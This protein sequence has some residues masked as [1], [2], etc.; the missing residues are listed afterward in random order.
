M[1]T[2][3]YQVLR[4]L[5]DRVSGEFVNLGIVVYE[6]KKKQLV[7]RFYQKIT[8]VSSFFPTVNS[9]YLAST[10]K[11][12][13]KEFES[14]CIKFQNEISFETFSSIEEIT[15]KVLPK[16]DSALFFTE[17]KKLLEISIDIAIDDLYDKFVLNYIHED[18]RDYV[19]DKEVWADL[20][21]KYFDDLKITE[22]LRNHTVKT[23][24][25]SWEFEKAW[26]NGIWNCFET[27]SFDLVKEDSIKEKTYK[28]WG[29]IAELQT[30]KEPIHLYLLSKMPTAHPELKRFIKKKLGKI[31]HENITI[32]LISDAG[33]ERFAK[34]IQK[35]I[36]D[37]ES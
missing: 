20:Y 17:A 34:K 25:D 12:L 18:E 26:K 24:M 5:P 6:P 13:Q 27:I 11:F 23:E 36:R 2:Y 3:Q 16:D 30:S 29:K 28:W 14:I 8:R 21:K 4:F 15:K 9:R 33:A 22:H 31:E 10:L 1:N 19:T 32:E 7:G 35:E 37:H